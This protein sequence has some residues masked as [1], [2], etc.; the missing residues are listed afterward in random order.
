[1]LMKMKSVGPFDMHQSVTFS[2]ETTSL[3]TNLVHVVTH[4]AYT[5][6]CAVV[7][8]AAN[9]GEVHLAKMKCKSFR[10]RI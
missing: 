5:I 1:M 10:V 8:C 9:V 7:R 6:D 3:R 2:E 4:L